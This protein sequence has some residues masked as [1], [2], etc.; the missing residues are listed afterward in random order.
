MYAVQKYNQKVATADPCAGVARFL[1]G[2]APGCD[3]A[4]Y[5]QNT[6]GK[7]QQWLEGYRAWAMGGSAR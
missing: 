5:H 7:G 6:S 4:K 1:G 2:A 3:S